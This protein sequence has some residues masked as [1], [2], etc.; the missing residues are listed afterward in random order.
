MGWY[1]LR[2]AA[3]H[4]LGLWRNLE[5]TPE[6][7]VITSGSSEAFEVVFKDLFPSVLNVAIEDPSWPKTP[8]I[9]KGLNRVPHSLP[10]DDQ[11]FDPQ[12]IPPN[13]RAVVVTP[14]RHYPTGIPLAM[15]RR[16]ALLDWAHRQ[17][18][19]VIEDDYDSE[20]LYKGRPLPSLAGM[21]GLRS[22][23]CLGS[24]SKLMSPGLRLGYLVVPRKYI[25]QARA[26]LSKF[27]ARASLIPQ[28]AMA[29]FMN[30]GAFAIHLKRMRRTYSRRQSLLVAA[31]API[32]DLSHVAADPAGMH[33]CIPLRSALVKQCSDQEIAMIARGE[34]L[35]I[36][37]L[38]T[39]YAHSPTRQALLLGY[40]AFDDKNLIQ[41]AGPL[42]DM[43]RKLVP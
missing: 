19:I 22:I 29:A 3:A 37:P 38:S 16:A 12:H 30:E 32:N 15:A 26:Y 39:Y 11:G 25:A 41:A 4:H 8:L 14:S 21:D 23:V 24:F 42:C 33:L 28:P 1:P 20:S 36:E 31:L 13:C 5:C 40:A 6:Q 35:V 17:G 10:I 9:L 34:G 7:I 18:G 43:V 27:G 2:E